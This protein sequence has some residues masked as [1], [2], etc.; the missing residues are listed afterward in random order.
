MGRRKRR[1]VRRV[2]EKAEM[3]Y[4]AFGVTKDEF[5]KKM[6]E[7]LR[8]LSFELAKCSTVVERA[9]AL[10]NW[11]NKGDDYEKTFRATVL[12]WVMNE[13]ACTALN[14]IVMRLGD[15]NEDVMYG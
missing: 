3:L 4:E 11:L 15:M 9:K 1:K 14:S 8:E 12:Y 6:I 2:N 13:M 5:V 10:L 7:V